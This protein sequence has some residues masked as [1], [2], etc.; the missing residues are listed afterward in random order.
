[1]FP[2]HNNPKS[3]EHRQFTLKRKMS[4][5]MYLI[6][7]FFLISYSINL[8]GKTIQ[9]NYWMSKTWVLT[10]TFHGSNYAASY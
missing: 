7:G 8:H 1:M 6:G 2:T 4:N 10:I 3:C 9:S 5:M